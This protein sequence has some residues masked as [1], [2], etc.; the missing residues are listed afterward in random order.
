[1]QKLVTSEQIRKLESEWIKKIS[2][3]WS[4]TLMEKAGSSL[5][6]TAK[7][8]KEPYLIICG[9]GN[10]GGDGIVT[11]RYLLASGKKVNLFLTSDESALSGDAKTNLELIKNKIQCFRIEKEQDDNFLKIL[12]E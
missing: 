3:Q 10:N 1:M 2:P 7:E 4:L 11:A 9:K 5:A 8:Y 6:D 12:S